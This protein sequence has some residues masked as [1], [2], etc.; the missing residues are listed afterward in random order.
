MSD[1]DIPT[2]DLGATEDCIAC[3][4]GLETWYPDYMLGEPAYRQCG[5]CGGRGYFDVSDQ[6][7]YAMMEQAND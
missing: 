2:F 5:C 3:Q 1:K 6:E 7:Y 4:D